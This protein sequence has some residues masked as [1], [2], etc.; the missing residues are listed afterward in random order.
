MIYC[1][2]KKTSKLLSK[3]QI[4]KK[5]EENCKN[6]TEN[7]STKKNYEKNLQKTFYTT[8]LGSNLGNKQN[9]LYTRIN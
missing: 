7:F 4:D 2:Y 5:Y 8:V 1:R 9:R 6:K 3:I